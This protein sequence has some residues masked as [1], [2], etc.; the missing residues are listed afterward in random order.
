MRRTKRIRTIDT[1]AL[2][3]RRTEL[4]ESDLVVVLFTEQL[5]QLSALARGA[6]RSR[7]RFVGAL[8]PLHT[9][10]V[11]LEEKGGA[12]LL[13]LVEATLERARTRLLTSLE[14]MDAAGRV[15]GWIRKASPPRTPEPEVWRAVV[16]LLDRL[17]DPAR[18][19][20]AR[21]ELVRAGLGL[22]AAFGWGLE[23]ERCVGC[24]KPC[25]EGRVAQ[26]DVE[27]GGL[28]CRACGGG[29]LRLSGP[30]R[31]RL[32]GAARGS[33]LALDAGDLG[34]AVEIVDRAFRA[35]LGFD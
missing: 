17:D 24:G 9:L 1:R 32:A 13:D 31:A 23:L 19:T 16:D 21:A 4:G 34:I 35:H 26:I 8:E 14:D 12:E 3:V 29:R 5:G 27:R 33:A 6:R 11:R 25:P 10:R 28:L 15:L 2:L 18:G 20:S 30:T 22:L 7:R